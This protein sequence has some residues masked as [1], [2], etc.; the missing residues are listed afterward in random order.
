MLQHPLTLT[1]YRTISMNIYY[2]YQYLREDMTPYYIGKGKDNRAWQNHKRSNGTDLLPRDIAKI[3][4][5]ARD[6]YEQEA[7]LLET[8]LITQYGRKD[9]GTGILRNLTDGGEGVAG[10]IQSQETIQKRVSKTRGKKRSEEFKKNRY[11]ENNTFYNKKH[12][13]ETRQQ[14]SNNHA[15]VS[16]ANNPMY[17]KQHPNKGVTGKWKWSEESRL[18]LSGSNN[19]MF[20]KVSPN[21]GKT[22]LKFEC[23]HCKKQVSKG[24]LS[25]WHGNNCSKHVN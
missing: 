20:G 21:R 2:V 18:K 22:P 4:I 19:P 1:V 24:N 3:Q 12:T 15:D 23:I 8:K 13:L 10:L 6:L 7:H 25:R 11:G 5:L 14:M 16:G 17:G 9:L